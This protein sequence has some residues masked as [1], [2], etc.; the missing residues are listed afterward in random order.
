MA[1]GA[2]AG[3]LAGSSAGGAW[4]IGGAALGVVIGLVCYVALTM[5]Y[6]WLMI[7]S[8]PPNGPPPRL[9][10]YLFPPVMLACVALS[11][12]SASSFVHWLRR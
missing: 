4:T 5:P 7:D 6:V 3:G 2:V 12:W 11:L 1:A 10:R 9:F 8:E